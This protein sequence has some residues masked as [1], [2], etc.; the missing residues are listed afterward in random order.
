M[1]EGRF[2]DGRPETPAKAN[3]NNHGYVPRLISADGSKHQYKRAAP[4]FPSHRSTSCHHKL[5]PPIHRMDVSIP[6]E[7]WAE[8]F[9]FACT[10]DGSTG[11]A[12]SE[13]SWAIH[14]ISKP[15]K[16]QSLCVIGPNQL[17]ML[18]AVLSALLP[19]ARKVRYLFV[20]GLDESK[21]DGTEIRW[22]EIH[23][24]PTGSATEQALVRILHLVSPS[25]LALHIHRTKICRQSL[26]PEMEFPVLS[27]LTLHGPFRSTDFRPPTLLPALRRLHIHHFGYQPTKL[28]H[29]IA[30][31][32]PL[33]A[34]LHVPQRS[35]PMHEIQVALGILQP[36]AASASAAAQLP[37]IKQLVIEVDAVP[38]SLESWAGNI[39]AEQFSRKLVKI[40]Q[41]DK[42]ISL[43][44]GRNDWVPVGQ[45]KEEWLRDVRVPG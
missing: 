18:L 44:D 4:T 33:L 9:S 36:P 32:A 15:L 43:V 38:S 12:L 27:E 41:S 21:D 6:P 7:I 45:A 29:R 5:P 22:Q 24:D 16:Y 26:F 3:S 40:A 1:I 34:H 14:N 30:D 10:D 31:V 20:A 28:L 2:R 19:G 8:V 17:R 11:R 39:R 13:V 25:L 23:A 42:R 37:N 35:F